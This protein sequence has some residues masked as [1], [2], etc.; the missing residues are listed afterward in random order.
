MYLKLAVIPTTILQFWVAVCINAE[1]FN[2][3]YRVC[4]TF[5]NQTHQA[6]FR[7]Q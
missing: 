4:K 6:P 5:Y 3:K 7:P 2:K 1:N